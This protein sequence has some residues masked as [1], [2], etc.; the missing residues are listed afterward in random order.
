MGGSVQFRKNNK[1]RRNG[2]GV[3]YSK[4]DIESLPNLESVN[5]PW[6]KMT[7]GQAQR[8]VKT[9][10]QKRENSDRPIGII[11]N[12]EETRIAFLDEPHPNADVLIKASRSANNMDYLDYLHADDE[13][14]DY[15]LDSEV[16]FI[17]SEAKDYERKRSFD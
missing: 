5:K 17:S 13:W 6:L 1:I 8:M 10:Y 9:L 14:G 16:A 11:S 12:N 15:M 2:L 3:I 7:R 4:E